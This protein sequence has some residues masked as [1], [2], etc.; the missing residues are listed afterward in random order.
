MMV[1]PSPGPSLLANR[2]CQSFFIPV[3]KKQGL[4]IFLY[5]CL[6]ETGTVKLFPSLF[7]SPYVS[8]LGSP[9]H[10]LSLIAFHFSEFGSFGSDRNTEQI[11]ITLHGAIRVVCC[12]ASGWH[13]LPVSQFENPK[14]RQHSNLNFISRH[15]GHS[16]LTW[17]L[18]ICNLEI[19][20]EF[21]RA[22][23]VKEEGT[24]SYAWDGCRPAPSPCPA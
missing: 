11:R 5:P 19:V 7:A 24:A 13:I 6:Q 4:S 17:D 14:V 2:D 1:S 9:S 15:V 16:R 21:R 8:I 20:R 12:S 23:L 10:L 18:W 22:I 3:C